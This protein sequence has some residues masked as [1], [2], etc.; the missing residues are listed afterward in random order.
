MG[1]VLA[2]HR[3]DLEAL[4][5]LRFLLPALLD[6][7]EISVR[8]AQEART[9]IRIKNEHVA[10]I[11]DVER[12]D[13]VPSGGGEQLRPPASTGPPAPRWRPSTQAAAP[14]RL[15]DE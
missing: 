6:N 14:A 9:A 10:R 3:R 11:Y 13:G 1:V 12:V 4:V 7:A 2:A 15:S 5:A 8:F